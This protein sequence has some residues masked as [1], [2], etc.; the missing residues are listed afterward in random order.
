[1]GRIAV[2]GRRAGL[3][4]VPAD[5][6]NLG[7][8]FV[9]PNEVVRRPPATDTHLAAVHSRFGPLPVDYRRFLKSVNGG[10]PRATG[11]DGQ[12]MSYPTD[13]DADDPGRCVVDHPEYEFEVECFYGLG[14]PEDAYSVVSCS[15]YPSRRLGHEVVAIAGNGCGDHLIFL[16]PGDP[17]VYQWIHDEAVPPVPMAASFTELLALV[18]PYRE[19][20]TP[21]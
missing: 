18:S 19:G 17:A 2:N 3:L 10:T 9:Y 14:A 13:P 21:T 1:V 15:R 11:P 12:P 8:Q 16:A 7:F 6:V 5:E 20:Q 4:S